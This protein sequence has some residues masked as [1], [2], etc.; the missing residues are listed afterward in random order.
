MQRP[1]ATIIVSAAGAAACVT[2]ITTEP[3][4]AKSCTELRALCWTMRA[5]KSD[6]TEPYRRCRSSGVFITP[7]GRVFK[8]TS[9]D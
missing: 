5:A 2:T 9:R 3:A 7:L 8:A 1:L 4:H 6:C